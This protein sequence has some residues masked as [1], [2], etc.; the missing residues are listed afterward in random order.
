MDGPLP[1][2]ACILESVHLKSRK[3]FSWKKMIKLLVCSLVLLILIKSSHQDP[4][5][6]EIQKRFNNAHFLRRRQ[7]YPDNFFWCSFPLRKYC[8]NYLV[9]AC[10]HEKRI[11][12]LQSKWASSIACH[13]KKQVIRWF[14]WLK[15]RENNLKIPFR[16]F[17]K[18]FKFRYGKAGMYP[19]GRPVRPWSYLNFQIP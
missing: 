16:N 8:K 7:R 2:R 18:H 3:F 10:F 19:Q 15:I 4:E 12:N 9:I 17:F 6:I 14:D 13:L 11:P 1:K 5:D